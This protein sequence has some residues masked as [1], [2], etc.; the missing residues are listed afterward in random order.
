MRSLLI[1]ALGDL[2]QALGREWDASQATITLNDELDAKHQV[3]YEFSA[4]LWE[5]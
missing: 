3:K 2:E 5:A 4:R 1:R